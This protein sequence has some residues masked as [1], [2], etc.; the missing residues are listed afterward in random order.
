MR[1]PGPYVVSPLD[2]PTPGPTCD[3][4]FPVAYHDIQSASARHGLR[5]GS[6]NS[7]PVARVIS[8][9]SACA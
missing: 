2:S 5:H 3:T 9:P 7:E 4:S 8:L 1:P 6:C